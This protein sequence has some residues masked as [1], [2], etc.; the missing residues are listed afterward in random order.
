MSGR[1][2]IR[3]PTGSPANAFLSKPAPPA[4]AREGAPRPPE[5]EEPPPP[6]VAMTT[7][8]Q[9]R[10]ATPPPATETGAAQRPDKARRATPIPEPGVRF[11]FFLPVHLAKLV[12]AE[13]ERRRAAGHRGRGKSDYQTIFR[14][15]VEKHLQ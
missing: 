2:P 1:V 14:D 13:R 4:S 9:E 7:V 3:M 10:A 11:Q 8:V 15:L 5:P 6:R 12:D